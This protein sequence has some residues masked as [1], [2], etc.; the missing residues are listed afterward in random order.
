MVRNGL[1][2][3]LVEEPM[4]YSSCIESK[5]GVARE[6]VALPMVYGNLVV[7]SVSGYDGRL[8]AFV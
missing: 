8:F 1:E 2:R 6:M 4:R 5:E 3:M 7:P